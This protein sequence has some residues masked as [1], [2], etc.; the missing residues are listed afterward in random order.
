MSDGDSTILNNI[1]A[2]VNNFLVRVTSNLSDDIDDKDEAAK[3]NAVLKSKCQL[4]RTADVTKEVS[5]M[6]SNIG[7]ANSPKELHNYID[8]RHRRQVANLRR[9]LKKE[10]RK[11]YSGDRKTHRSTPDDNG[12]AS[13]KPSKKVATS[14][15]TSTTKKSTKTSTAKKNSAASRAAPS[16]GGE[17]RGAKGR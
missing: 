2:N 16:K 13:K 17:K 8:K 4:K 1:V 6:L 10:M 5:Q 7:L 11:K 14:K 3:I 9:E 12:A 15:K